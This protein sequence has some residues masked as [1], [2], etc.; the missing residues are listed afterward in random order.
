MVQREHIELV[1]AQRVFPVK[2][3]KDSYD[4]IGCSQDLV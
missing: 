1:R 2:I 3:K 4:I